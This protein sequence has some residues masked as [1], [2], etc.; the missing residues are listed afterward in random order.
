METGWIVAFT[1]LYF[2]SGLVE[3][4]IAKNIAERKGYGGN[5]FFIAALL[6][7]AVGLLCACV[8]PDK[9]AQKEKAAALKEISERLSA[10]EE[11]IGATKVETATGER[12]EALAPMARDEENERLERERREQAAARLF[13][14]E[15]AFYGVAQPAPVTERS[16]SPHTA[17]LIFKEGR[18]VCSAC[19]SPLKFNDV[20]CR[21]CGAKIVPAD[22][23]DGSF[24]RKKQ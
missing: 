7:N 12:K 16:D 20:M 8:L 3:A 4:F 11:K 23:S 18:L 5:A 10:I 14:G 1:I 22:G 19:G 2:L 13:G 9:N 21:G 15:K 6:S 24:I 17:N